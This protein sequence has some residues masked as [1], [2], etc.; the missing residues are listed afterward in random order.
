MLLL[1][2]FCRHHDIRHCSKIFLGICT[3]F[4]RSLEMMFLLRCFSARR[5]LY[6]LYNRSVW[7]DVEAAR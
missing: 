6:V 1:F 5:V 2:L 3:Y 4:E 7:G